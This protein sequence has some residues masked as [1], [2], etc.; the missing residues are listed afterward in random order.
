MI[1]KQTFLE[2]IWK[3]KMQINQKVDKLTS[4][5]ELFTELHEN[6]H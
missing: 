5:S 3:Q 4:D 1:E 2:K 6:Y